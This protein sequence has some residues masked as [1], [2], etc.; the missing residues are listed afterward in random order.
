MPIVWLFH[1]DIHACTS[2]GNMAPVLL[3]RIETS[4]S[5]MTAS[6]DDEGK[7]FYLYSLHGQDE[8]IRPY[9]VDKGELLLIPNQ[10][11]SYA[12]VSFDFE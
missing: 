11:Q 1:A 12:S 8:R 10:T 5:F 7:Y 2:I 3:E 9:S 6:F 4:E